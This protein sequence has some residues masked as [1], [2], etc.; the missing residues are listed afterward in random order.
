VSIIVCAHDEL[1][2]LK[3]LIPTLLAQN[4]AQFEIIVVDDR[5][6]DETFDFLLEQ[7][8]KDHRVRMVHV[9][10]LPQH[11][12]GKKYALTLGIKAAKF[13]WLIFTD[14]DCRPKTN[15]W[16]A[17]MSQGFTKDNVFVLGYSPYQTFPTF[18][19]H[20]IRFET[21]F[22]AIQYFSWA[23]LG[24]PYMGVGRNLAYRRSFFLEAKGFNNLIGVTGGDDD[25]FVNQYAT[26]QNTVAIASKDAVVYSVPKSTWKTFYRQKVRHLSVG[27][28]Y[29]FSHRFLLGL[30]MLSWMV[31]WFTA[32]ALSIMQIIDFDTI[33][34]GVVA[35]LLVLRLTFLKI[36]VSKASNALGEPFNVWRVLPLDFIYAFYYL[37]TGMVALVTKKVR[38]KN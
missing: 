29:R 27:K 5:S 8:N 20:F 19:N 33:I 2:N 34:L 7:T 3:E 6:N 32:I 25:L 28:R 18:L 36:L 30:F 11:V 9:N 22:T 23:W 31:V 35:G 4:Y 24:K 17:A 12:D 13:E 37:V 26:K 10:R 14:A 1:Q 38:W 15:Q 21:L 16:L